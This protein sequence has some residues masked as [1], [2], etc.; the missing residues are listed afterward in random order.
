MPFAPLLF[1]DLPLMDSNGIGRC[2]SSTI[3][4]QPS[5]VPAYP[6]KDQ[7]VGV[8]GEVTRRISRFIG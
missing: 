2:G 4:F 8:L 6:G 1:P 3:L 7:S 5:P